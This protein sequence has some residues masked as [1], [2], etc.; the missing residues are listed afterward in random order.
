M[1][2]SCSFSQGP[3]AVKTP[4]FMWTF[5]RHEHGLIN[6]YHS[7]EGSKHVHVLVCKQKDALAYEK[8]WPNHII[9]V[10]PDVVN[11][12]GPGKYTIHTQALFETRAQF[13]SAA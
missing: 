4:I 6:L 13:H 8:Q 11:E 12:A 2:S 5:G 9:L 3:N 1:D 10:L 7:M